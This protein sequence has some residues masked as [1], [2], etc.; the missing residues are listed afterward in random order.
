MSIKGL[1]LF[2][3]NS[4]NLMQTLGQSPFPMKGLERFM[5]KR[6]MNFQGFLQGGTFQGTS[7][8]GTDLQGEVGKLSNT[9]NVQAPPE[10]NG[11]IKAFLS[12]FSRKQNN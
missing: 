12:R 10:K 8:Q 3:N 5:L 6:G 4:L 11:G 9:L 7:L 1:K 2:N